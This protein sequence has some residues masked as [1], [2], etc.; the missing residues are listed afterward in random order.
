MFNRETHKSRGFGFIV[1]ESE[2]SV[3]MVCAEKE[4]SIDGKVVCYCVSTKLHVC[5][6]KYHI[7]FTNYYIIIQKVEVK[8][9][10]PR[11]KIGGGSSSTTPTT[12]PT[13]TTHKTITPSI[14]ASPRSTSTEKG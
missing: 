12:T 14:S 5:L 10:V 2:K 8:R 7:R 3:D 9:A 13:T 4:H 1:Y 11:S 6:L